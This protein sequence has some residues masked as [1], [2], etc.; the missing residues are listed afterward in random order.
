M[1]RQR[2]ELLDVS[3]VE[4][5]MEHY[6]PLE[7]ETLPQQ[8]IKFKTQR[9]R[10]V[11]IRH[12]SL[13]QTPVGKNNHYKLQSGPNI[14]HVKTTYFTLGFS[15]SD[16]NLP[17][18]DQGHNE[19]S[20]QLL[21]RLL[22]TQLINWAGILMRMRLKLIPTTAYQI[23]KENSGPEKLQESGCQI[24]QSIWPRTCA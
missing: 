3:V 11:Q 8:T 18:P 14:G 21:S 7:G 15:K 4:W 17:Q 20:C 22:K 23:T 5:I 19:F 9:I 10:K 2:L 13:L 16:Q 1:E 6:F 12:I 24:Y